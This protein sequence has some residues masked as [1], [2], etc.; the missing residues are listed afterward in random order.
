MSVPPL[1]ERCPN[2]QSS[3]CAIV[4]LKQSPRVFLRCK[5]CELLFV[6]SD[7]HISPQK[8]RER[9]EQ[10][11]NNPLDVGYRA[12]LAQ[13]VEP[14]CKA[15]RDLPGPHLGLDWGAGPGPTVPLMLAERGF[16]V[17]VYDPFF[18]PSRP[19]ARS[20][21]FIVATEVFEH[22]RV[23]SIEIPKVLSYL[24]VGGLLAVM[25]QPPPQTQEDLAQWFY[26]RDPTHVS[27]FTPNCFE[28]IAR[29]YGLGIVYASRGAWIFKRTS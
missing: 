19:A 27:F 18:G 23:P 24:A 21:T 11:H 5:E 6:R 12:F 2:C 16:S 1:V 17:D 14:L 26:L 4:P 25:T 29:R 22:F 20:Y 10:H 8:E 3:E 28:W 15:L 9:Y 13:V 7:Y